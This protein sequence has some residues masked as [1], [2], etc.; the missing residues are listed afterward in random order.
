[1]NEKTR[2]GAIIS[3]IGGLFG[4]I[5]NFVLFMDGYNAMYLAKKALNRPDEMPIVTYII[6]SLSD[7]GILG[8]AML[9]VAA[10][11]FYKSAKWSWGVAVTGSILMLQGSTFAMV[12]AASS[13]DVPM[14]AILWVPSF[15]LFLLYTLYVRKCNRTI[16]AIAT[17]AGMAYVLTFFNGVAAT[18]RIFKTILEGGDR[19]IFVFSERLN[20]FSTVVWGVF[21]VGLLTKR[22]YMVPVGIGAGILGIVGGAP[23]AYTSFTETGVFSMFAFGVLFSAALLVYLM[24]PIGEKT[25][26]KWVASRDND[27]KPKGKAA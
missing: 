6:P 5:A 19:S 12:P 2:F 7:M 4:I 14:Y 3:L 27:A 18:S 24:L 15:T 1:M 22:K 26:E 11:G 8:S 20:W 9:L 13:G 10:F 16:V 17:V 21:T 25:I 23:L